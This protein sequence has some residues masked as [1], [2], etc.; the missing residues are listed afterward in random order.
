MKPLE[1]FVLAVVLLSASILILN[2]SQ[3]QAMGHSLLDIFWWFTR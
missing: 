1:R 2:A 3:A